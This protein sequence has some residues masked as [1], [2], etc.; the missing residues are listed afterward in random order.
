MGSNYYLALLSKISVIN[1]SILVKNKDVNTN[2]LELSMYSFCLTER[3]LFKMIE[4]NISAFNF[5]FS[6]LISNYKRVFSL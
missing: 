1:L 4:K 3:V 5:S 2:F 6:C